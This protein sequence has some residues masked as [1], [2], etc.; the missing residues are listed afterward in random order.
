[1]TAVRPAR[2]DDA[3]HILALYPRAFPAEDLTGLVRALL[4]H[5]A[6]LSLVAAE[7]G[8]VLGHILFTRCPDAA[9]GSD[10]A[11][12]GPLCV[13]PSRQRGGIGT[14]LMREG[15]ARLTADG[16]G[17]VLVLGDPAYYARVGF[18]PETAVAPPYPLPEAWDE[19]WRGLSLGGAQ[20][21]APQTLQVPEVWRDRALW[22][23]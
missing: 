8:E 20:T 16:V 11:L 23:P 17:R 22:T 2:P 15:F 9:D 3:Q 13:A 10:M 5:P 4:D 14:A 12:L 6:A 1:M 18:A 19:A 21:P 7:G